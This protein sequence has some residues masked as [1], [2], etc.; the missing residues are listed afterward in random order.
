MGGMRFG[1]G[2][3]GGEGEFGDSVLLFS[4]FVY[5]Y[6]CQRGA[7]LDAEFGL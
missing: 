4:A 6:V 2:G 3:W 5:T 1:K 7:E